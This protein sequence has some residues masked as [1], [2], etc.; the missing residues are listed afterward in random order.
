[1]LAVGAFP[2][3]AYEHGVC[4]KRAHDALHDLFLECHELG[5]KGVGRRVDQ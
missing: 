3:P 4:F 1:V 5:T 2:Y